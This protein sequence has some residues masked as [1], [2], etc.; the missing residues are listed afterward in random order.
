QAPLEWCKVNR[1]GS[2][3]FKFTQAESGMEVGAD[4]MP[5]VEAAQAVGGVREWFPGPCVFAEG[6]GPHL[7]KGGPFD[8]W[9]RAR[10][11]QTDPNGT[12]TAT[13][14]VGTYKECGGAY[15]IGDINVLVEGPFLK[16][17]AMPPPSTTAML[18]TP[19]DATARHEGRLE[20]LESKGHKFHPNVPL[21]R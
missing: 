13:P 8:A 16:T 15:G 21:P 17:V 9:C 7:L 11:R 18:G 12:I 4:R 1:Y 20:L 6:C 14:D 19:N 3:P 10:I 2:W 5:L